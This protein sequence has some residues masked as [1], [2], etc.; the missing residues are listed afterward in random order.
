VNPAL[1]PAASGSSPG[2]Q[3]AEE[4]IASGKADFVSLARAMLFDPR[5][6]WHAA[7][8]LGADIKYPVQYERAHPERL[9]KGARLETSIVDPFRSEGRRKRSK[10]AERKG[11]YG[12]NLGFP[13]VRL[14]E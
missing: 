9:G 7:A 1:R 12:G 6:P 11:G 4:I 13:S 3:Q 5:W 10:I 14:P 8:A 2:A